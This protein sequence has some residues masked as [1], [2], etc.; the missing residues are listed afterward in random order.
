MPV[1]ALLCIFR[2]CHLQSFCPLFPSSYCNHVKFTTEFKAIQ[3]S[4]NFSCSS[5]R[6]DRPLSGKKCQMPTGTF[7]QLPGAGHVTCF[8]PT[9]GCG[10][11]QLEAHFGKACSGVPQ[12]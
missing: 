4:D 10:V 2:N 5:S 1:L 7:S 11:I 9:G 6:T 12:R 8:I 3:S